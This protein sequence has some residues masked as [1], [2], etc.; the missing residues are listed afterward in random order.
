MLLKM[1]RI[2]GIAKVNV[3][4]NNPNIWIFHFSVLSLET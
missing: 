2:T 4:K 3:K 1:S